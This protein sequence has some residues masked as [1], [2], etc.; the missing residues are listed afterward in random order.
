MPFPPL[1]NQ[2]EIDRLPRSAA[3]RLTLPGLFWL[4][5]G[6]LLLLGLMLIG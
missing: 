6:L 3:P 2:K 4:E 5:G 1:L